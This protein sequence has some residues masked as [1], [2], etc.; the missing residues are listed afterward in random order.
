M[1]LTDYDNLVKLSQKT[2]QV[3]TRVHIYHD[4]FVTNVTNNVLGRYDDHRVGKVVKIDE[5]CVHVQ[6]GSEANIGVYDTASLGFVT[7][8]LKPTAT[9]TTG[10]LGIPS[11]NKKGFITDWSD[12]GKGNTVKIFEPTSVKESTYFASDLEFV[13][14]ETAMS[15]LLRRGGRRVTLRN[16]KMNSMYTRF[17][18]R[19]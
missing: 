4:S 17:L 5:P 10:S 6:Y 3:G 1:S 8:R 7:A 11:Q 9:T 19:V 12:Y 16:K 14:S 15:S 13:I 2:F 18:K